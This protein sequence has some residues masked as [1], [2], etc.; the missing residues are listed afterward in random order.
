MKYPARNPAK[1]P[2][3]NPVPP[4]IATIP[5]TKPTTNPGRFAIPS[6]IYAANTGTIIPIAASPTAFNIA[7]VA[8]Y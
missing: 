7:A 5:P 1:I 6:A 3:K 2:P 8:L 4:F